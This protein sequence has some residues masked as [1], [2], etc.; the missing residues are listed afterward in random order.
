MNARVIDGRAGWRTSTTEE[1][2]ES[3]SAGAGAEHRAFGGPP[4]VSPAGNADAAW[5]GLYRIGAAS[6]LT[7][8]VLMPVQLVAWLVWPPPFTVEGF[9]ALFRRNW[10]VG[11][12]SLDLLYMVTNVLMLPLLLALCVALRRVSRSAIAIAL[13]LGLVSV[14]IYF[15]STAA[16]EML[17]LSNQH[18][19]ATS[20]AQRALFL[21]AG[22][23]MLATY[24]GTAFAVYYLLNGA[25][26]LIIA[27]I[28]LRSSVFNRATGYTGL[29]SGVLMIVPSTGGT[30]G[31]V[32]ALA[33]LVPWA[34][35][36]VLI[37]RRL[38]VLAQLR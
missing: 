6:A 19:S 34:V 1:R 30:V 3:E 37:A 28:M 23:A 21:A 29:L 24:K 2:R 4:Y 8:L 17:S 25:A 22:A 33:S 12:I 10:L 27:A 14:T 32:F 36:S 20:D 13:A 9:F 35:F 7:I 16:F 18:A 38:H 5:T 31:L 15:A 26:L 11:L